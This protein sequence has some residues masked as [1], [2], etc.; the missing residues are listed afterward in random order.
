MILKAQLSG[1]FKTG[2]K[3]SLFQV[4]EKLEQCGINI[5]HPSNDGF[6]FTQNAR[7]PGLVSALWTP[8]ESN[9]DYYET[10]AASDAYVVD[11]DDGVVTDWM[12]RGILYAMLQHKPILLL[13]KPVFD[14]TVGAF[15]RELLLAHADQ[16]LIFDIL[17][18]DKAAV[19]EQLR[20]TA[21]SVDYGL[22]ARDRTII[23]AIIRKHFR[24]L[25]ARTKAP[26]PQQGTLVAAV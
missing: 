21:Q 4:K 2:N 8:Y 24:E 5:T 9:L 16:F 12:A 10:T 15:V 18:A 17:T 13:H 20:G 23:Q 6:I 3:T 22:S 14:Q 11:N 26:K 25:L 19:L 7:A 1:Q